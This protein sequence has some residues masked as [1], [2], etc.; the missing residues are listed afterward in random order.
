[1]RPRFTLSVFGGVLGLAGPSRA[2]CQPVM[3]GAPGAAAPV[4]GFGDYAK[5]GWIEHVGVSWAPGAP[6][7][8]LGGAAIYGSNEHKSPQADDRTD[9]YGLVGTAIHS[10]PDAAHMSPYVVGSPGVLVHDFHSSAQPG[11]ARS[12]ARLAVGAGVGASHA[13]GPLD[14]FAQGFLLNGLGQP[15][16]TRLLGFTTGARTPVGR[17][18]R[19]S[20]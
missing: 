15:D 1:M 11:L 4:G 6:G 18:R 2:S 5:P 14:A 16:D 17:G 9:T 7:L 13:L 10:L 19:S 20:A 12:E 8:A 3:H